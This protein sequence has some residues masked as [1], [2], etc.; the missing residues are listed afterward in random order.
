MEKANLF[1]W[2]VIPFVDEHVKNILGGT[3]RD[4]LK[5]SS[6]MLALAALPQNDSLF[7]KSKKR[8]RTRAWC[9]F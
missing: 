6:K 9:A 4:L 2:H 7:V 1:P 8:K 3:A 5:W